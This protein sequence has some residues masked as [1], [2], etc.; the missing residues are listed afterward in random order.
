MKCS[1]CNH[2][3]FAEDKKRGMNRYYCKHRA[4]AASVNA[5]AR[6]LAR[7]KR[8]ETELTVKT[9]PR[10]CPLKSEITTEEGEISR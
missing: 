9:A 4:A 5:G 8:H 6:L 3:Q 7:T 10:W 1:E 2:C